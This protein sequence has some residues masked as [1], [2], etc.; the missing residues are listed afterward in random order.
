[1]SYFVLGK[2]VGLLLHGVKV[3][4]LS[5]WTALSGIAVIIVKNNY[6]PYSPII[7]DKPVM[8]DLPKRTMFAVGE[9]T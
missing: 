8:R 6:D 9:L 7:L 4:K 1:M 2:S 5:W 3:K